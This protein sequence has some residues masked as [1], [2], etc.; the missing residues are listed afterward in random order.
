LD[1][2]QV[3]VVAAPLLTVLGFAERLTVG[4][5]AATETDAD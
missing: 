3:R 1:E 4:A 5:A 2:D